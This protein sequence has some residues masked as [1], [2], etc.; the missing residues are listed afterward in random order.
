MELS[1]LS[2]WGSLIPFYLGEEPCMK[3]S[4]VC[5]L[6]LVNHLIVVKATVIFQLL[7]D[8][9]NMPT[10][11]V[12]LLCGKQITFDR[13]LPVLLP[14]AREATRWA[15]Q[16]LTGAALAL[17]PQLVQCEAAS[18]STDKEPSLQTPTTICWSFISQRKNGFLLTRI[19]QHFNSR[20]DK[21]VD[22]LSS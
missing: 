7:T 1:L 22:T 6:S 20:E 15:A 14:D 5:S 17:H 18:A 8:F 2:V 13:R 11:T 4:A 21:G 10:E 3:S 12:G 9:L 19:F 16:C